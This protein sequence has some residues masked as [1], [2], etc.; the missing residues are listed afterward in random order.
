[1]RIRQLYIT[2]IV[3]A[4]TSK[5][6]GNLVLIPPVYNV[7]ALWIMQMCII[8]YH[9]MYCVA[10]RKINLQSQLKVRSIEAM[11]K[12]FSRNHTNSRKIRKS[13]RESKCDDANDVSSGYFAI[14]DA[15]HPNGR[16]GIYFLV[17]FQLKL[18]IFHVVTIIILLP[19]YL[20]CCFLFF[21]AVFSSSFST[22]FPISTIV[23][24]F[25]AHCFSIGLLFLLHNL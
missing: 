7:C 8:H 16:G 1:M 24:H 22:I 9:S 23:F 2:Q 5:I 12:D 20:F 19:F 21:A 6:G 25:L 15:W 17:S 10:M 13:F 3:A 18:Q 14:V 4:T 11:P